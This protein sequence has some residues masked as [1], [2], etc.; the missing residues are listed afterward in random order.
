MTV[1]LGKKYQLEQQSLNSEA[2]KE[3]ILYSDSTQ[4]TRFQY[5]KLLKKK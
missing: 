2:K 5:L 3:K 4:P 1:V